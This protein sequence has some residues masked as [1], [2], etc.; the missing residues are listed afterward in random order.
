MADNVWA[1][2][3]R[4]EQSVIINTEQIENVSDLEGND[5]D[6]EQW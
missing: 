3:E 1:V 6:D 5:E 4:D 2:Q